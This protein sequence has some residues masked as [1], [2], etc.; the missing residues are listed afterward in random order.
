M[1][2]TIKER[3]KYDK[4]GWN[5]AYDFSESDFVVCMQ[6]LQCYLERSGAVRGPVPWATLKYLFGEV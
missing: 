2:I 3:R 4:I 6:I 5:I 1:Y